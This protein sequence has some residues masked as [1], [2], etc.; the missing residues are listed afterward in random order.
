M[1]LES[2]KNPLFLSLKEYDV[3]QLFFI[4]H[5]RHQTMS[6]F[7]RIASE[8]PLLYPRHLVARLPGQRVHVEAMMS[9]R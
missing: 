8:M 5:N 6:Q 4:S 7:V 2:L 3:F 1:F 9:R